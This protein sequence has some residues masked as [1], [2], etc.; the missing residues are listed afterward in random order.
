MTDPA[1]LP[2]KLTLNLTFKEAIGL[3]PAAVFI[4][5]RN[6]RIVFMNG[7]CEDQWGMSFADMHGTV[8]SQFFPP[9]QMERFLTKDQEVFAGGRQM[10]LEE[11]VWNAKLQEDRLVHTI[12]KPIYDAAGDPGYLIGITFDITDRIRGDADL[13]ESTEKLLGLYEMSPLGIAL[14]DMSGKFVEFNEAFRK[15]CGYSAD[16]LRNLDYWALTPRRYEADEAL[17]LESLQ[18]TG[19]YRAYEKEYLC[20]DG[21]LVPVQ[22]NGMLITGKSGQSLIWSIVEDITE[23]KRTEAELEQHRHHL[24]LLVQQRT[25]E[26]AVARQQAEQA[27]LAKSHFL[28]NMS[29]EI[30]T[31]LN[32][33]IGF[34]H[35]MRRDGVTTAQ[36]DRLNKIEAASKHLLS[37]VSDVLDLSKIEADQL[38]LEDSS[39]HLSDVIGPV[40]SFIAEGASAKGLTIVTDASDVP[41]WLRGDPTRL[42]QALLNFAGNAVKFTESGSILLRARL[43]EVRGAELLV[44]FSVEDTG[45]GIATEQVP[46]LFQAFAQADAS[47]TRK[48]GGTGLGLAITKRLTA[49]MG[50]ECGVESRLGVGSTFWFT[51]RLQRGEI[52]SPA[53]SFKST[54]DVEALLRQRHRGARILVAEDN[55]VNQEVLSELLQSVGLN[56]D[57]A[58]NGREAVALAKVGG[59]ALALMDLQM[60]V[61]GGLDATR[62]IREMPHWRAKPILALT[63]NAFA[64]D[65][66]ACK[67]AGM[68][69]FIIKPVEVVSFYAAILDWLDND[70]SG[71]GR[72]PDADRPRSDASP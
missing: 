51:A 53:A 19:H 46:R 30:R 17:Q 56:A 39:F 16:E 24:E 42:R 29:H 47:T 5:D 55:P 48:F 68:D 1:L 52:V 9:E 37:L 43:L 44:R 15:I 71:V 41:L 69:D 7:A 35:L 49:L 62:A 64:D 50:G 60:P 26:L 70:C 20:K 54:A 63:A 8:G 36:A 6:S 22:L 27:S 11:R 3:I 10:D 25:A 66:Q 23:R 31:P 18:R 45:V 59:Y 34:N 13:R 58:A 65:R 28:A 21:T 14:T 33:I 72:Q 61:M 67:L 32:A 12:K 38:E 2:D 57:I 40:A 4:K